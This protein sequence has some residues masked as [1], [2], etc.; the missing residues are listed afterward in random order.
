MRKYSFF[1]LLLALLFIIVLSGCGIGRPFHNGYHNRYYDYGS[2]N[3]FYKQNDI[4]FQN[5]SDNTWGTCRR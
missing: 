2:E 3:G 4:R 1:L 5:Y